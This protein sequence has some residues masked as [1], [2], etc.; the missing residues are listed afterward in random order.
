MKGIIISAILKFFLKA[1]T[2]FDAVVGGNSDVATVEKPVDIASKQQAVMDGMR[3]ALSI[4]L[5][6]GGFESRKRMLFGNRAGASV[7]I[8]DRDLEGALTQ[9]RPDGRLFAVAGAFF[10]DPPGF[11]VQVKN[12]PLL[13]DVRKMLPDRPARF[14][15]KGISFSP[16]D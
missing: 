11:S 12:F 7:G 1:A 4:R 8:R 5:D 6:M 16:D 2:D 9:A 13:P 14:R 3:A 15:I 10:L